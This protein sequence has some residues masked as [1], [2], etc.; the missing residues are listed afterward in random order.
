MSVRITAHPGLMQK[1]FIRNI[2]VKQ[3]LVIDVLICRRIIKQHVFYGIRCL[4]GIPVGNTAAHM[5]VYFKDYDVLYL[6]DNS[7]G[8]LHNT[9]TMRGAV[10]RDADFWSKKYYEMYCRYGD[11]AKAV[12][13]GHGSRCTGF[14]S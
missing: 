1:A 14:P 4:C 5:A 12:A 7:M 13:Q 10:V 2:C 11:R 8:M 6:G 3:G 9:Y